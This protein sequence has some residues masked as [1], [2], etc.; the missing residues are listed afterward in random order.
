MKRNRNIVKL[1]I[2]SSLAAFIALNASE[3][4]AAGAHGGGHGNFTTIGKAGKVSDVTRT[5]KVVMQDNFFELENLSIKGGE[6][7]RFVIKN[8]GEFVHEFNIGT[9]AMHGEHFKE[10]T[11]MMEHG[12]LEPDK[13]NRDKMK[14]DMGNGKTMQHNDPNS[15]L[16]E[17]GKS[18]EIIWKFPGKAIAQLE[19]ACNIPGHYDAGMMG[20]VRF[21]KSTS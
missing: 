15:V 8:A 9:K 12:V 3:S 2:V 21:L 19:F 13:I 14:M 16:L 18:T 7:I 10:M 4:F 1:A 5:V 17:P 11:K 20:K 6:T